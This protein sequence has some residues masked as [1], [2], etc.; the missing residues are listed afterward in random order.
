VVSVPV[1]RAFTFCNCVI[2]ASIARTISLIFM[3][4]L[5]LRIAYELDSESSWPENELVFR[6]VIASC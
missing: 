3:K 6:R 5:L 4:P 2:S 1:R